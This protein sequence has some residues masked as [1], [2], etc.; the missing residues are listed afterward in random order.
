MSSTINTILYMQEQYNAT[1]I[2]P[3]LSKVGS[4][5]VQSKR[6]FTTWLELNLE[7][8][9]QIFCSKKQYYSSSHNSYD[10]TVKIY[11]GKQVGLLEY[12][13]PLTTQHCFFSILKKFALGERI[14]PNSH[15][16]ENSVFECNW[17]TV[18]E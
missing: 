15:D 18:L 4:L 8:I 2:K 11:E 7:H 10:K 6:V 13:A 17:C 1:Q 3:K 16:C 12:P 14:L 5:L 9:K